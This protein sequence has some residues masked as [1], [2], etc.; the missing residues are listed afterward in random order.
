MTFK[1][2]ITQ[3]IGRRQLQVQR[4]SPHIMFGLGLTGSIAS[5]VLACRAT[6]KLEKTLEGIQHDLDGVNQMETIADASRDIRTRNKDRAYVYAKGGAELIKLYGPPVVI[7]GVSIAL[8]TGSHIQLTRRNTA[9]TLAYTTLHKTYMEYR[10]RV[11]DQIGEEAENDLANGIVRKIVKTEDGEK[12]EVKIAD[13]NGLS[14][15]ARFFDEASPNWSKD[16]EI[17]RLFVQC[18]QKYANDLLHARGHVF[19]NEV[20]D[21]LGIDRSHAGQVVGWSINNGGDNYVS[22]GMFDA[23][24]SRFVNG[25]ER[26][27]LLDFNVDGPILDNFKE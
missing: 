19:L 8:L 21:M 9:L 3:F 24:N 2:T 23:V 10:E 14:V 16:P 22:F 1:S 13:P 17:N 4:N 7:G 5:T 25:W 12:V 27:I 26:S 11:R 15:Y 20:Y 6:L 18:Q